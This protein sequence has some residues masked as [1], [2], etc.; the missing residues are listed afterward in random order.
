[1]S[2]PTARLVS[3]QFCDDL[4]AAGA[5]LDDPATPTGALTQAEGARYLA[6]IIAV[7][8]EVGLEH[9]DVEH[10]WVFL[11]R[12]PWKLTGGVSSDAVYH[13]AFIDGGRSYRL[14][15]ARGTAPMLEVGVYAG[16]LGLQDHSRL[17]GQVTEDDLAVGDDGTFELLL[18]P[19]PSQ[20]PDILLAPDASY[21]YIRNYSLDWAREVAATFSI[22]AE[23][24]EAPPAPLELD[25]VRRGFDG[26][27]AYLQDMPRRF[28]TA[29]AWNRERSTNTLVA[30]DPGQDTTMPG[31]HQL[32][33]GY[34]VLGSDQSLVVRFDPEPA[35]YWSLGLC[36]Y[37]ME[38]LDWRWRTPAINA[39]SAR[40]DHD[41]RVTAV[42]GATA[43]ET[44]NWIDI[45]GHREGLISFR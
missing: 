41:G 37:W 26:A 40:R 11:A 43:P 13:E 28:A 5:I 23:G 3:D 18:S 27:A 20:G 17:V 7:G 8:L 24:I 30:I 2:T 22:R 6:R 36:N 9:A 34:F 25:T 35:P 12:T 14:R 32:S 1:M 10:P 44:G 21:I 39:G 33:C 42:I 31:G 38:P 16:K 45:G 15:G 19:D 4:K 29:M